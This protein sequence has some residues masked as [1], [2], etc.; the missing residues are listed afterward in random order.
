MVL[1]LVLAAAQPGHRARAERADTLGHNSEAAA[2]YQ[3]AFEEER[4]PELLY[5]L[6]LARRRLKEWAK[7]KAAFRGYLRAAP[8]GALRDEV[9]RQLAQLAIVME[10]EQEP[11]PEPAKRPAREKKGAREPKTSAPPDPKAETAPDAALSPHAP[12]ANPSPTA[13][14]EAARAQPPQAPAAPPTA[15][16]PPPP[17]S[18][19]PTSPALAAPEAALPIVA[20]AINLKTASQA[21]VQQHS[22]LLPWAIGGAA[23]LAAGGAALWWSGARISRDLDS[24]FASGDLTSADKPRYGRARA[25]SIG[26]R[27]LVGASACLAAAGLVFWW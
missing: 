4:A 6:G 7:A 26:G 5:R 23:A 11:G 8:D 12:A 9:E 3:A 19:T 17:A 20:E 10:A 13:A 2:E 16:P 15:A 21:P 27:A 25:E 24:R 1:V 18:A 22:A 14:P